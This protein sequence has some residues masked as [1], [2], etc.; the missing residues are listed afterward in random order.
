MAVCNRFDVAN[1]CDVTNDCAMYVRPDLYYLC[2]IY[3]VRT[4]TPSITTIWWML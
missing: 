3:Q 1:E 4:D 2:Q